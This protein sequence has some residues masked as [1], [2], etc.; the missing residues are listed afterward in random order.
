M[1]CQCGACRGHEVVGEVAAGGTQQRRLIVFASRRNIGK[2][3]VN[4]VPDLLVIVV[5]HALVL[6]SLC[7]ANM[8][9]KCR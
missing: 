8:Y 5:H 7:E 1:P 3:A 4:M 6:L 2:Q 9:L